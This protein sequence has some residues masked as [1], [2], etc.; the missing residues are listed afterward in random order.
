MNDEQNSNMDKQSDTSVDETS[1]VAE[2]QTS[3]AEVI[4]MSVTPK[5]KFKHTK[6][7]ILIALITLL[8]GGA[9]AGATYYLV[10]RSRDDVSNDEKLSEIDSGLPEIQLEAR[11]V[12]EQSGT[13]ASGYTWLDV[14]KQ[15]DKL[16]LFKNPADVAD[17]SYETQVATESEYY[18]IGTGSDKSEVYIVAGPEEMGGRPYLSVVKS[19]DTLSILK[20]HSNSFFYTE[21]EGGPKEYH[22]PELLPG[23]TVDPSSNIADM[24]A[25]GE[26]TYKGQRFSTTYPGT[27]QP[28]WLSFMEK[29][30]A[31]SE[32][33]TYKEDGKITEGTV[34]EYIA[35]DDPTY[36]VSRFELRLKP[37]FYVTLYV[38]GELSDQEVDPITWN[39]GSVNTINYA[40]AARGCG[41]GNSNEI[42]KYGKDQLVQIGK[43]TKGQIIY[44]F[45][46]NSNAL[47]LK[48][49]SEY[50]DDSKNVSDWIGDDETYYKKANFG[51]AIGEYVNLRPLYV[52]EDGMGRMLV[53]S[54]QDLVLVGGCAKPVVYAYPSVPTLIDVSVGADVTVS[55]PLYGNGWNGVL[56]MPNGL[57]GYNGKQYNSL[58]WEG[59]GH[60][61]YP[62]VTKGRVVTR[63]S[64]ESA[65]RSDLAQQG[66]NE[67][68]TADFM[69][70][71]ASKI[72]SSPYVRLSWLGTNDMERLAPLYVSPAPDT[73]IRVFLDM[74]GLN[75]YAELPAQTLSAP[76]R[77]GFTVVEWGGLVTDGSV[78]LLR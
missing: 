6:L 77:R 23:V 20:N 62:E 24:Q 33:S 58:F 59:Y 66:L 13:L 39:D 22:G 73:R 14:P 53:F 26:V 30:P 51:L 36:R 45:K 46:D 7:A 9:S 40:S 60:G 54:R 44:G 67:K 8:V 70:F 65:I 27:T 52:V 75:E 25:P 55:D 19:G 63:S 31:A 10:N 35:K 5:R 68:E 21:V 37:P 32:F 71:W 16:S 61:Q 4:G 34:Y 28:A 57:L 43:S 29:L 76:A 18:L 50:L 69:D 72:P 1:P 64:A 38:K 3:S 74:E 11:S 41:S 47:L 49:H 2:A 17:T 42:A 48:H 15:V 78:P 56:A 12:T